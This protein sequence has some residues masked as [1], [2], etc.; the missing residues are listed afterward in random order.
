[1]APTPAR[2]TLPLMA[3]LCVACG[4]DGP[5]PT[6]A[7]TPTDTAASPT[8]APTAAPTSMAAS[9]P[10]AAGETGAP[11]PTAAPLTRLVGAPAPAAEAPPVDLYPSEGPVT[12]VLGAA[13]QVWVGTMDGV[14]RAGL[15]GP[16]LVEVWAEA[17]EPT[18]T[19]AVR[20]LAARAEGVLVLAE[21]GLFH[22]GQGVLLYSPLSLAL[23]G[24]DVG[25][26]AVA[27]EGASEVV[28]IGAADGLYRCTTSLL[29]R[30]DVP[31]VSGGP[32]ALAVD[33]DHVWVSWPEGLVDLDP[34]AWTYR[35]ERRVAG[36]TS[37][38]VADGEVWVGSLAG[39][40]HV[41]EELTWYSLD[42]TGLGVPIGALAADPAGGVLVGL[43]G[44]VARVDAGGAV[45]VAE[46]DGAPRGIGVDGIGDLWV[47]TAAGVSA[48]RIGTPISFAGDVA[49]LLGA[50]CNGCHW[51]SAVGP[52]H[53]F[54][55]YN[56]VVPLADDVL[57]RVLTGQMPPS[58]PLP[59]AD[60][61]TLVGW[62]ETG[63]N[64]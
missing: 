47:G 9:T 13:G 2:S 5:T 16:E 31:G 26:V 63:L 41:G 45:E 29:E 60:V 42:H 11:T 48:V 59:A 17:G 40:Y 4:G 19:G 1:M 36:G 53:D 58:G 51:D 23:D 24:L 3:A 35:L 30:I 22:S 50:Q 34:T 37:V 43:D 21:A 10:T 15:T 25:A 6:A 57:E 56:Q 46:V 38:V 18:A 14:A 32:L 8:A 20:Q 52:R 28:W 62:Y 7:P 44:R 61:D 49:P 64:P 12:A 27:G 33:G 55:D 39:L 54:T